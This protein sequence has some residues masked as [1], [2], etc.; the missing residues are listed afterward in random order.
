MHV[1]MFIC[2]CTHTYIPKMG[3]GNVYLFLVVYKTYKRVHKHMYI[4]VSALLINTHIYMHNI[5][6]YMYVYR[7]TQY[8]YIYLYV[9][10]YTMYMVC[11]PYM[12]IYKKKSYFC[13]KAYKGLQI[14]KM[15]QKLWCQNKSSSVVA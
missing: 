15:C 6:S 12:Y 8:I 5:H 13:W 10:V 11:A 2:M 9:C 1:C 3:G 4:L 14:K 7:Y